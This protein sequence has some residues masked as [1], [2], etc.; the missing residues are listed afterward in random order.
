MRLCSEG[1]QRNNACLVGVNGYRRVSVTR[2]PD[3]TKLLVF[4]Y[5]Q[6]R[7]SCLYERRSEK[8]NYRSKI[9]RKPHLYAGASDIFSSAPII[10]FVDIVINKC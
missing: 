10:F 1:S 6:L 9:S 4:T 2:K 8:N 3:D 7:V 5:E